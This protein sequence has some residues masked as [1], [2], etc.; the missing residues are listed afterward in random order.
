MVM[1][2]RMQVEI[3]VH[4]ER[5][6]FQVGETV[7]FMLHWMVKY[8][9]R[10]SNYFQGDDDEIADDNLNDSDSWQTTDSEFDDIDDDD[11]DDDDGYDDNNA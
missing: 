1:D 9:K 3:N 5:M 8:L 6:L 2:I 7:T 11:I 10:K 4:T